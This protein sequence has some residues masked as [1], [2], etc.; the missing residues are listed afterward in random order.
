MAVDENFLSILFSHRQAF[1]NI[2]HTPIDATSSSVICLL[3]VVL[4]KL[5][6]LVL[7]VTGGFSPNLQAPFLESMRLH[8]EEDAVRAAAQLPGIFLDVITPFVSIYTHVIREMAI[9]EQHNCLKRGIACCST[10]R[11]AF[12]ICCLRDRSPADGPQSLD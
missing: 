2:I 8:R 7:N 12:T 9:H 11:L 10:S 4:A 1:Q 3:D 5:G 6:L